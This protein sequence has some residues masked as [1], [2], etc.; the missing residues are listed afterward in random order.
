MGNYSYL[1]QFPIPTATTMLPVDIL[2]QY[3]K[4]FAKQL[5]SA[6]C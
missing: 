5:I 6:V 4:H 2:L 3:N 1:P